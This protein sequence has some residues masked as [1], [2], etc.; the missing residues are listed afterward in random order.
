MMKIRKATLY[1]ILCLVIF[2]TVFMGIIASTKFNYL[3]IAFIVYLSCGIYL[4]KTINNHMVTFHPVNR[5]INNE[6][7]AKMGL[8]IF[9]PI[10]CPILFIK[11]AVIKY[12]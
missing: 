12:L 10:V 7:Q 2:L 6:F 3:W 4:S 8:I 9:W 5:T 1:Y 11:L